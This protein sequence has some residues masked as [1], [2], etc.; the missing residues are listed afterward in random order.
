M[1]DLKNFCVRFRH[2]VSVP[3]DISLALGVDIPPFASFDNII[4]FLTSPPC[5]PGTL[6]KYMLR[7]RAEKFFANARRQDIFAERI[8]FSY[9][10]LRGCIEFDLRFDQE[11]RL[12][13]VYVNYSGAKTDLGI[14]LPIE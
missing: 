7:S 4:R 14:E 9:Y 12:R 5:C 2:P 11:D 6:K 3:Q 8:L 10:F 1:Q 13:R